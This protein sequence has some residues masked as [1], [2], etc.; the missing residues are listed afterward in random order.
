VP[1]AARSRTVLATL[2]LVPITCLFAALA[3][4]DDCPLPPP[5]R[6]Q[7]TKH[8]L[9]SWND[10]DLRVFEAPTGG[11]RVPAGWTPIGQDRL[12]RRCAWFPESQAGVLVRAR[13]FE[14]SVLASP[15]PA[16]TLWLV[17]RSDLSTPDRVMVAA[18]VESTWRR[19]SALFPLGLDR[20]IE[21]TVLVTSGIAGDGRS[22]RTRLFPAPGSRLS[23][24]FRNLDDPR[25]ADL[26]IHTTVHVYNRRCARS[27]AAPD[28]PGLPRAEFQEMVAGWA[29]LALAENPAWRRR[30]V[31]D[32]LRDYR[33]VTDGDSTTVP[34][35]PFLAGIGAPETLALT[36]TSMSAVRAEFQHYVLAPLAMLAI[37]ALLA[38]NKASPL[39]EV[40]RD[41]HAGRHG[42]LLEG[43]RRRLP[44]SAMREVE[45]WLGG[46]RLPEGL[47]MGGLLRL[48]SSAAQR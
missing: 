34:A 24:V 29:E 37:D 16:V 12:E 7:L 30:R 48:E 46:A 25:G 47:M 40:L 15:D 44:A 26:L 8:G 45:R 39:I 4:A 1:E 41:I 36:S 42:G 43:L 9:A 28:E 20:T 14:R 27:E 3:K 35:D 2:G 18:R 11:C 22:Q 17:H 19:V 21:H 6:M 10:R 33:A 38:E 5:H 13:A 23:V 32:L 31:D